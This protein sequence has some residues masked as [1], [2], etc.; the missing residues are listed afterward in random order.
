MTTVTTRKSS[1]RRARVTAAKK[2]LLSLAGFFVALIFLIPYLRIL[3]TSIT[4]KSGLYEIP[5]EYF[6]SDL[7]LSN[8]IT[9]WDS[10]PIAR[11]IFNTLVISLSATVV[12]LIVAVPAAYYMARF[13]FR[14]R[15]LLLLLVLTTQMFSPTAM[16]IGIYR[17]FVTLELV[18]TFI[19]L[20][21][22]NAAFNLAFSTWIMLGFFSGIP[23]EIEEAA[24]VDG[25]SRF[26]VLRKVT[27]PL[28]LPGLL[29]AVIFTFIA[30]WN[31]FVIALTLTNT[32]A[33]RP[34]TV[35]LTAYVGLYEVQ[36]HYVSM[37]SL[38]AIVPVVILFISIEKWL[39]SGLTTGAI[40]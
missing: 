33:V 14:F 20:I 9:V 1:S 37:V 8:F 39:V 5:G 30:S 22:V 2:A 7:A 19:A 4:A 24:M 16:V 28:A 38:I 13:R 40:K 18:N 11:Y 17:Q 15:G 3:V 26:Q 12:V 34:L 31:E 29:T 25:A 27:L 35:G 23:V 36:W 10:A 6:P 21:L 32:E